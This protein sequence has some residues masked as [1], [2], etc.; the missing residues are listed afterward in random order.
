MKRLDLLN[1]LK[2]HFSKSSIKYPIVEVLLKTD[3]SSEFTVER[4]L[5]IGGAPNTSEIK[6]L[7]AA[8]G[9]IRL[10]DESFATYNDET[11][12]IQSKLIDPNRTEL[13]INWRGR[14]WSWTDIASIQDKRSFTEKILASYWRFLV[15][16]KDDEFFARHEITPAYFNP[17]FSTPGLSD[18]RNQIKQFIEFLKFKKARGQL[19][20]KNDRLVFFARKE[21]SKQF[22]RCF[23]TFMHGNNYATFSDLES[24]IDTKGIDGAVEEIR[25]SIAEKL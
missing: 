10:S 3:D 25:K 20:Y 17:G 8:K 18:F 21:P 7:F 13:S 9:G 4:T 12:L 14:L 15:T 5:M 16:Q 6:E 19:D 1:F 22:L 11:E 2:D 24:Y 23:P